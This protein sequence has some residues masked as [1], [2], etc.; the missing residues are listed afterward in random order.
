[1][2]NSAAAVPVGQLTLSSQSSMKKVLLSSGFMLTTFLAIG[3]YDNDSV[4]VQVMSPASIFGAYANAYAI[5]SSGWSVPDM[6]LPANSEQGIL[7][8]GRDGT[9]L[10]SLACEPLI[11]GADVAGK[12]AVVYRGECNFAL[13]AFNAQEAGA[14]AVLIF[15]NANNLV[16]D[17]GGGDFGDQV[18]IPV[19]MITQ[20]DGATIRAVMDVEDVD[21]FIGNPAGQF[22]NNLRLSDEDI[23]VPS[24]SSVPPLI[25]TGPADFQVQMG[26]FVQNVGSETQTTVRLRAVITQDVTELYNQVSVNV[27][28]EPGDTT[29]IELPQF[30]QPTYSGSYSITY[31]VE[32]DVADAVVLDNTYSV[33]LTFNDV[34]SY[35]PLDVGI[36]RP[37]TNYFTKP[38]E[39]EEE[40]RT[41][42][43]FADTNASRLIAT[44]LYFAAVTPDDE[45]TPNDSVLT[46][47]VLTAQAYRWNDPIQSAFT[48]PSATG[49]ETVTFGSYSYPDD[50]QDSAVFIPF[51]DPVVM[52]NNQRYLFCVG[53]S[54]LFV[55]HGWN[56]DVDYTGNA[57]FFA[58]PVS[59]NQSDGEWF[60][61]FTG[62][63]GVPAIG[64]QTIDANSVGIQE[65]DKVDITP[66]P[67]PTTDR[68]SIPLK[69]FSGAAYLQ[70][71]DM[72][73]ALVAEQNVAVG[74]NNV[75]TADMTGVAPGTYTFHLKFENGKRSEFR[76]VVAK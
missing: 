62:L 73:G 30:T 51:D 48:R 8:L 26:A 24:A 16:I 75:M 64:L 76:V 22:P 21:V 2:L 63:S 23:L 33:P 5:A 49:L 36:S 18:T 25:A 20:T 66:Y 11:N 37:V 46:D 54:D 15:S 19:A 43:Q 65:N 52:E 58:E 45:V 72:N 10:D 44:G 32:S 57:Q 68:I 70:I 42:V 27:T 28:L 41:C 13:K 55:F 38:A 12:I 69:G 60:N 9:E 14:I 67:N 3:Q 6:T 50:L 39:F 71:Y 56:T 4:V 17:M 31:T 34:H 59:L 7:R 40:F 1:M 29:F 53:T 47:I 74:G 61:G 35:G